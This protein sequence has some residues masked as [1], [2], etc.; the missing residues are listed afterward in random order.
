[1]RITSVFA[2]LLVS[3][4]TATWASE[5]KG[6]GSMF[7]APLFTN[8]SSSYAQHVKVNTS[9]KY[10][11]VNASEGIKRIS[12]KSVD[13]GQT[14]MPLNMDELNQKG[15]FQFPAILV[16]F[17]PIF[18]L[19]GVES[20]QLRLDGK[21]LGDIF[22][23]KISK[24]NDPAIAA[25][26]WNINLPNE[27]IKL[28]YRTKG[29]SGTYVFSN[30]VAKY[31]PEWKETM[32]VGLVVPWRV[33]QGT[34]SIKELGDYIKQTPYSLAVTEFS[35]VL[36]NRIKYVQ[37]KNR[38]GQFVKPSPDSVSEAAKL[39]QWDVANGF[40]VDLNDQAGAKTWP[41]TS[42]SFVLVRR[43]A[44]DPERSKEMLNYFNWSLRVGGMSAIQGDFIPLPSSVSN[45][46]R[47]SWKGIVDS[48]GV[49]IWQ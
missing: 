35:Y 24:W 11:S 28:A 39:A 4:T 25:L 47:A 37:L 18:N 22:M 14:D 19:P 17:T 48:K 32:G 43:V 5:L 21:T 27:T 31:N 12:N 40:Y 23:G 38:D 9:V 36:K 44:D 42:A 20:G 3:F 49:S 15:L 7:I 8:W 41:M 1:M 30:Y 33:G 46:V 45:T 29:T 34:E 6:V 26:N 2:L 13:F 16:A 10:E